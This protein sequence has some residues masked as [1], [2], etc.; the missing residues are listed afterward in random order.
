MSQTSQHKTL[1]FICC[2]LLIALAPYA[3]AE[4][5]IL[6]DDQEETPTVKREPFKP[7]DGFYVTGYWI[8]NNTLDGDF[9]D[10][11]Y[12]T[13]DSAIYDVP[14]IDDGQGFG[15]SLGV[16]TPGA[17]LE[18]SYLRT[19]HNTHS[20]FTDIGDQQ[21]TFNAIDLNLKI[22]LIKESRFRPYVLLGFGFPWITVENSVYENGSYSDETFTGISANV[23]AGLA[24]Y[25]TPQAFVNAGVM[26][27]WSFFNDVEGM[28]LDENLNA[29][30]F[31]FLLGFGYTF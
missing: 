3:Y 23:G 1:A 2:I 11:T 20:S 15:V 25:L 4:D 9:N 27:R 22:H 30:S 5:V 18:I 10:T 21:G 7:D 31:S 26:Q 6:L 24:F 19:S 29:S 8:A 17:S 12:Y 13:T 16:S 14:A 28:G